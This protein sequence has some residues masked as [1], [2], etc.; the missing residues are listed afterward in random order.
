MSLPSNEYHKLNSIRSA[1]SYRHIQTVWNAQKFVLNDSIDTWIKR[2]TGHKHQD[3]F[4][5]K[6]ILS[7]LN[8][9]FDRIYDKILLIFFLWNCILITANWLF[10]LRK[11]NKK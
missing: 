4:P 7:V 1:S 8:D 5:I 9:R 11:M 3:E 10:R 6:T 2:G